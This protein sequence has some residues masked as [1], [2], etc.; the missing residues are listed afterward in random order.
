MISQ[1]SALVSSIILKSSVRP[2]NKDF[3]VVM[4][5]AEIDSRY[6]P[7]SDLFPA[8]QALRLNKMTNR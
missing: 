6:W 7:V 8:P 5:P 1:L 3:A 4:S 2:Q